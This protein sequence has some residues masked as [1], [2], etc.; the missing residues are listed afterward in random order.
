VGASKTWVAAAGVLA[1]SL[2]LFASGSSAAKTRSAPVNTTP[3]S[4]S[5]TPRVGATLTG[6]AG[7]WSGSGVRYAYQ[8]LRCDSTG[9]TCAPLSGATGV[10]YG[11]TAS[12]G[13]STLRFSV[14]ASSR[15]GS[16]SGTSAATAAVPQPSS[17][18]STSPSPPTGLAATGA[19]T[20]SVTLAWSA[21]TGTDPAVGYDLYLNRTSVPTTT[22]TSSTVGGLAC[23][24]TYTFAVDAYDAAGNKSS[25]VST[26]APTSA[27]TSGSRIYWGAWIEGKQTYSYLYGG[28]WT[29]APWS[30][31]TWTKYAQ[32]VGK[33]PSIIHWGGGTFWDH[34]F[35]YWTGTLNLVQNAGALNLIDMDTGSASLAS[36]AAGSED[37]AITAWA[38][39]AKAYGHPFFLR[40]NWE[41]NGG[42]FP[43]G[44]TS[45][46][47][48]TPADYV[49]AWRHI[50]DIFAAQGATNVTWVWCP[51][52]ES[53]NSVPFSQLYPGDAYVDWTCLD[54]YN[55][56]GSSESFSSLYTQ[57]Y[58][59]LLKIAPAKPM[60]IG[61]VASLEYGA[62]T[63]AAW[64]S[65]LLSE[66]PTSFPQIKA[67]VW[68][69]WRN[70]HN[71]AWESNEVES[72]ATSQAA[73]A[74]GIAS[75]YYAA[76]SSFTMP[77][78]LTKIQPPP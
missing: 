13:G 33:D 53:S 73:F 39:Q 55:M 64:I 44:T 29:N 26:S 62:G 58:N 54:G 8:W 57:S 72:S 28:T 71:G 32:N 37:S 60:M 18:A 67:M 70:D 5:G 11:V 75:P 78:A 35:S 49:A 65:S 40:L 63:K 30:S 10:T 31:Q 42:W 7:T 6:E 21:S 77:A 68:F 48:N 38:Q 2:G 12:D 3:P 43:W 45:A 24:R 14:I 23:G 17:S 41:M 47:Q 27:C 74:T 76:A 4:I 51:N 1:V 46:N 52:L 50:H 19:T 66:L 25:Q 59:D 22:K 61:E 20:S 16:T 34:A 9:G 36:I 69:N 56:G 15:S